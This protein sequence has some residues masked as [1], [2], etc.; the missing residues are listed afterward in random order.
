MKGWDIGHI[1]VATFCSVKNPVHLLQSVREF[2]GHSISQRTWDAQG[3]P[4]LLR[5]SA[6]VDLCRIGLILEDAIAKLTLE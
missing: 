3:R 6:V 2:R 1:E 5:V 4:A